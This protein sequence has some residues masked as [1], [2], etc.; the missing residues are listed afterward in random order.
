MKKNDFAIF[1]V[2]I[3]MF[4]VAL[5]VGLFVI[6]PLIS[7]YGNSLPIHFVA[8]VVIG[9]I[10]GVLINAA[11]LELGHLAGAKVGQYEVL[12]FVILGVGVKTIEGKKKFGF[13]GFDGL[14]GET[15]VAPKDPE[16][17]SLG[18]YTF[19]PLVF[20]LVEVIGLMVANSIAGSAASSD[21]AIAWV[22]IMS[23]TMMTVGGMIF[24]YDIFP[25]RLDSINDGYLFSLFSKNGNR[26][27]YNCLLLQEKANAL[28]EEAPELPIFEEIT[29]FTAELNELAAYRLVAKGD[30]DGAVAILDKTIKA[31]TGP[32][33]AAVKE[34]KCI[35]LGLL[36]ASS[37]TTVGKHYYEEEFDDD[38]KRYISEMAH[39][40]ALRCYLLISGMIENSD[41]ETNYAIDK[42]EKVLK[43]TEPLFLESEKALI[44]HDK[45][46]LK[47]VHPTWDFYPLPW[48][49]KKPEEAEENPAESEKE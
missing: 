25:A 44:A 11:L 29:D 21:P 43:N 49:E 45:E 23:V 47:K 46:F 27:A 16:K 17:S 3:A 15:K 37:K 20:F 30:F 18:S 5:L 24:L 13:H 1:L 35:K 6:R 38:D 32:S 10:L 40:P 8:L 22:Q 14:T 33:K 9:L 2:Y 41:T 4:A 28:Q 39:M 36:L 34:A 31:E 12:S 19:L 42:V 26:F 48:E 7:Q